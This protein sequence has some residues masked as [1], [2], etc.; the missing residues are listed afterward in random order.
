MVYPFHTVERSLL[1][2]VIIVTVSPFVHS[3]FS[4]LKHN[5]T[6]YPCNELIFFV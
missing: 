2:I 6:A 3:M 1:Q 4:T 5:E